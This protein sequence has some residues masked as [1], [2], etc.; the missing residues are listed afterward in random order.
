MSARSAAPVATVLARRASPTFP[1]E[2]RSPMIPEPTTAARRRAVPTASAVTRRRSVGISSMGDILE[3]AHEGLE[4]TE[5]PGLDA[6]ARP[7]AV[8][9]AVDEPV[10]LEDLEVLGDGA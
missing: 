5:D 2:S 6:V 9:L 10:L 7:R 1:P 3:R 8:D 4:T